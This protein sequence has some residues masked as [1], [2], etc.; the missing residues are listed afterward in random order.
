MKKLTLPEL[1]LRLSAIVA[2]VMGVAA[3]G[4]VVAKPTLVSVQN[5]PDLEKTIP[6]VF[7]DW[8]EVPTMQAQVS[9]STAEGPTMD[10]PYDQTVMRSY[11]NSRGEVVMLAV[12]WGHKQQQEVK[13]HRPDLCY[14]AQGYQVTSL[15]PAAFPIAGASG[16][17]ATGKHMVASG[18]GRVEAVSYW[19]RIGTMYSENAWE[20]RLRILKDGFNGHIPDGILVR[21]SQSMRDKSEVPASWPVLDRFLVDLTQ[22]VPA[23]TREMMVR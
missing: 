9:T 18:S 19:I 16:V 11:A 20:T 13:V 8:K 6:T 5:P 3:I 14:V 12:A 23:A 21:A 22:A 7:G 17:P 10:Q 15:A 2:L 1:P 4:A